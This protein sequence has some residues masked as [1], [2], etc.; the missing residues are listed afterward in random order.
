MTRSRLAHLV[1]LFVTLGTAALLSL[2]TGG[3]ALAEG[4]YGPFPK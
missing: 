4:G 1:R 2:A 3:I